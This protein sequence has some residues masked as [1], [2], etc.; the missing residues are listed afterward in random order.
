MRSVAVVGI[1]SLIL[2]VSLL[3]AQSLRSRL[4]VTVE[5]PSGAPIRDVA[6]QVQHWVG[7]NGR[8]PQLVQDGMLTTDA[9]GRAIFEVPEYQYEVLA[10]AQAFVPVVASVE[11]YGG[12]EF[13]PVFK[14][15]VRTGG[16]VKVQSVPKL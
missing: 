8:K 7:G 11:V 2:F 4:L 12:L 13:A 15:S 16:G 6:V 1:G 3:P 5:D 14:L 10:S 9:Q